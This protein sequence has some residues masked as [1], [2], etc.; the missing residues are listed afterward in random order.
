MEVDAVPHLEKT[1]R[2]GNQRTDLGQRDIRI[3][4]DVSEIVGETGNKHVHTRHE[5]GIEREIVE[6]ACPI[7]VGRTI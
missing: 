2:L 5:T 6:Q 4:A 3:V 1:C 7:P